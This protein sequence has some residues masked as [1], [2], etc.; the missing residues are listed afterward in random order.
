VSMGRR[1][2]GSCRAMVGIFCAVG[3][4]KMS[5][6]KKMAHEIIIPPIRHKY[7][8]NVGISILYVN[9]P[10]TEERCKREEMIST[11]CT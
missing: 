5:W 11:Y 9:P 2:F 10:R 6:R 8:T 7:Q 4:L 3:R 1:I